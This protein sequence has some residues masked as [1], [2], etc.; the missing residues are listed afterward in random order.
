[1]NNITVAKLTDYLKSI[2]L[3]K[4]CDPEETENKLV[5]KLMTSI[6][7]YKY[8]SIRS[9]ISVDMSKLNEFLDK[10]VC[11]MDTQASE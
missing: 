11:F 10:V 2:N 4:N 5:N 1:M 8:Y 9:G 7:L 6:M 3:I